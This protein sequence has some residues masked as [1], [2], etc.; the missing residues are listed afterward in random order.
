[1]KTKKGT[2]IHAHFS[3]LGCTIIKQEMNVEESCSLD[4]KRWA[5][6][7]GKSVVIPYNFKICLEFLYN[8][9]IDYALNYA[10]IKTISS[11]FI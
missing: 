10:K 5:L 7:K 11:P 9:T 8:K 1:V 3:E 2:A 6:A 4:L